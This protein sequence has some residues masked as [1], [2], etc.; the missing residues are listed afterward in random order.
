MTEMKKPKNRQEKEKETMKSS[1]TKLIKEIARA[2]GIIN[3]IGDGVTILDRTFTILYEN[4]IHRDLAGDHVGEKCYKAYQQ[5]QGICGGCPVVLTFKEG[6]V[7]AV[8]REIQTDEGIR[9][10]EITASPLKDSTGK[11]IA[12]IE[13]VRDITDRKQAEDA[14]RVSEQHYRNVYNT[15]PLAFVLWDRETR[16][17]DWNNQAELMFGWTREEIVGQN[18]FDY[19][20]PESARTHVKEIVKLLLEGKLPSYS[21]NENITKSGR[22]IVCEWNN[23]IIRDSGGNIVEVISLGL[24]ITE[25]K[26]AEEEIKKLSS[27]V[28][29][30]TEGMATVDF[31]GNLTFVNDA[32]CKMHGYESSNELLGKNLAISHNQ[33]QM[34][35]D[36]KP[37]NDKV[38]EFGA[39][40]GEVGH[41]TKDGKPFPTLMTST[42]LKDKQGKPYA[43][44]GIAKDISEH[45]RTEEVLRD[46]EEKY[47]LLFN[48]IT[49]AVY[50]HEVSVEKPKKFIAV[51]NSAC[52]M[53]GYTMD[54]FLQMEVKD[55][56]IPEQSENI[57]S[58]HE[59]LYRDGYALFETFHVAKDGRRIPVEINITLFK[60]KGKSMV[61]S[62]VRDITER[63][64]TEIEINKKVKELEEF[65]DMAVGRE[66]RMK[67]LKEENEELKEALKKHENL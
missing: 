38:M 60:L 37:F 12:G 67:Q 53:L 46:S 16:V 39:Y 1:T 40:S 63:K 5:R 15:S 6:K 29:Q 44:V 28:Q 35:N 51:N 56:D 62:V 66:L 25:R 58:I 22:I 23:S 33:E 43:L 30:S 11:I 20:I 64:Q 9:Y 4:Q 2:E 55:I 32:W 14:L 65:Y 47:R 54:N 10:A 18:F 7:H 42:V 34:E 31:D 50:V 49:D 17:T 27:V 61:L 57:P 24:D 13:V 52:R 3:A 26:Q 8:Q 45:K 19:I 41:I 36:V 48:G 59:K 21:I